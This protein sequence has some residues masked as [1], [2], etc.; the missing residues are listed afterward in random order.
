MM[1]GLSEVFNGMP[2]F[3]DAPCISPVHG[4]G[5]PMTG[6]ASQDDA[7]LERQDRETVE[8]DYPDVEAS[9]HVQL[10]SLSVETSGRWGK[11]AL[12]LIRELAR[13]IGSHVSESLKTSVIHS[14]SK[15]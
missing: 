6:A 12:R 14:Y 7:C 10:L 15:R 13:L 5:N 11:H 3:I 4:D 8:S 1:P 2:L 9:P